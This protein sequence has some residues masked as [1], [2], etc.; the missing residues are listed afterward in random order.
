[1]VEAPSEEEE[2]LYHCL[3]LRFHLV[4]ILRSDEFLVDL[5][6]AG[7][8]GSQ[9]VHRDNKERVDQEAPGN[10]HHEDHA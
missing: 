6:L 10:R 9:D 2:S 3:G 5:L 7:C 1:M 4:N 8:E